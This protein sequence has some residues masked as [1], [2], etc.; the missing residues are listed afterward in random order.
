[1]PPIIAV[2]CLAGL[3][4]AVAV[5]AFAVKE[6]VLDIRRYDRAH[7]RVVAIKSDIEVL[8]GSA[9]TMGPAE[10][11]SLRWGPLDDQQLERLL[12]ENL[13]G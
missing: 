13:P 12:N 6:V 9:D 7:P 2:V 1:M 4:A 5:V 11:R 3:V 8:P 10:L